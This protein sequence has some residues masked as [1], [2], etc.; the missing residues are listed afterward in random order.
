M[1]IPHI[2]FCI[3]IQK[4]TDN[5]SSFTVVNPSK[6]NWADIVFL[7]PTLRAD[8]L[9]EIEVD[10]EENCFLT[11]PN[12]DAYDTFA[13]IPQFFANLSHFRHSSETTGWC[14][15]STDG[16]GGC[17][18]CASPQRARSAIAVTRLTV[19]PY[20]PRSVKASLSF[21]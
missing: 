8:N 9:L 10:Y 4:S 12:E 5:I 15:P 6:E 20:G 19:L 16:G 18:P 3:D 2:H 13:R 11:L 14:F 1:N 17:V 21:S 7:A